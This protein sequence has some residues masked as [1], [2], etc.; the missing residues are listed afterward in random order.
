MTIVSKTAKSTGSRLQ[1]ALIS[2]GFMMQEGHAAAYRRRSLVNRDV[3]IVAIS[4]VCEA[5][6]QG[7]RESFPD[8][9]ENRETPSDWMDSSHVGWFNSLFDQFKNAVDR[10]EYVGVEALEAFRCVQLIQAGYGSSAEDSRRIA[11]AEPPAMGELSAA[12]RHPSR[13]TV[14]TTV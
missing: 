14:E 10:K 12:L 3:D 2:F 6:R 7:A 5:R 11:L 1:G 9:F 8:G 4:D 13:C